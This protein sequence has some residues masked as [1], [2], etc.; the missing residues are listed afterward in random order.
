MPIDPSNEINP[1]V[2]EAI[3]S[4]TQAAFEE[5][6]QTIV[7]PGSA[8]F[9]NADFV[10]PEVVALI[11]LKRSIPGKLMLGI[12]RHTLAKLAARYLPPGIDVT[13]E[14]QNDVAGEFAN[15]IGGQ[16]KTS[17]QGTPYHFWLTTPEIFQ[18]ANQKLTSTE[19]VIFPFE[20]DAGTFE[21]L[22]ELPPMR[23]STLDRV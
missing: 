16:T 7:I 12:S 20:F 14:L 11:S 6:I 8:S 23:T 21:V 3:I 4:S 15:V 5:L 18:A 10:L 9:A 22:I 1:L 17:L 13:E 2:A 19:V